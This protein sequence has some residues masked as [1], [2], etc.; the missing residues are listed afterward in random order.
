MT[1]DSIHSE[2]HISEA[3]NKRT[4]LCKFENQIFTPRNAAINDTT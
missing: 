1:M 2:D 3:F 4:S